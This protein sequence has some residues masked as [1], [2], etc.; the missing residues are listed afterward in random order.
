M[1]SKQQEAVGEEANK[2]NKIVPDVLVTGGGAAGDG[3]MGQ[4]SRL[5][6]GV[7]LGGLQK[8][9]GAAPEIKAQV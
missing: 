2:Q 3:L 9:Q 5:P 7:D 6:P 8:K 4:L 1:I